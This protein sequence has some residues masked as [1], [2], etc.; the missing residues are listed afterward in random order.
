MHSKRYIFVARFTL[1]SLMLYHPSKY[2]MFGHS[3]SYK[4]E[5]V[6]IAMETTKDA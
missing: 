5:L 3:G 4:K 1:V 6:E 2:F